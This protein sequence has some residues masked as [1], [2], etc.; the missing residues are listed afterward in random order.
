MRLL[1]VLPCLATAASQSNRTN[2]TA[3]VPVLA[4]R[5]VI[6]S[7]NSNS[8]LITSSNSTVAKC[9]A[10]VIAPYSNDTYQNV[11]RVAQ[12]KLNC[13]ALNL[14]PDM[15]S[16]N[17][18]ILNYNFTSFKTSF[19][20][21]PLLNDLYVWNGAL[22]NTLGFMHVVWDLYCRVKY[23]QLDITLPVVNQTQT[24]LTTR[25]CKNSTVP[26]CLYTVALVQ[27]IRPDEPSEPVG[28]LLADVNLTADL[29]SARQM[30]VNHGS[31][32][33]A[34]GRRL[35]NNQLLMPSGRV[36][37]DGS[38]VRVLYLYCTRTQQR[39][40]DATAVSM[41]TSAHVV[42]NQAL[43]NSNLKFTLEIAAIAKVD[44]VDVSFEQTIA[45]MQSGVVTGVSALRDRYAADLVQMI[46]EVS[47]YCGYGYL[48]NNANA[49]FAAYGFSAVYS[50]CLTGFSGIHEIGHN[51]GLQHDRQSATQQTVYYN[52]YAYRY[53][54]DGVTAQPVGGYFRSIMAYACTASTRVPLFSSPAVSYNGLST[55]NNLND[56]VYVLQQT[57]MTVANFRQGTGA[58]TAVVAPTPAP[59]PVAPAP[60]NRPAAPTSAPTRRQRGNGK[61]LL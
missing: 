38:T 10:Q 19:N 9:V 55:G 60:T 22:N 20:S 47:T 29:E 35:T 51:M 32:E 21:F 56:N 30:Q 37:D 26:N 34:G 50:S 23:F 28:R 18:S 7:C 6:P 2:S 11:T 33:R 45:D 52:G 15:R 14:S 58:G 57:Y 42:S 39:Y 24:L 53:C 16:F 43:S 61:G 3:F 54:Q 1:L 31:L 25:P 49:G 4:N 40:T 12:G 59:V 48:M 13:T 46:I 41:I 17:I 44:Y 36:L 27:K 5:T 8:S